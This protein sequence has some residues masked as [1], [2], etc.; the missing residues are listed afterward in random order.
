MQGEEELL[1]SHFGG[2][3]LGGG[4]NIQQDEDGERRGKQKRCARPAEAER[5]SE[6]NMITK[7]LLKVRSGRASEQ[8]SV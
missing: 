6:S 2:V 3:K 5:K 4:G 1:K 7:K 8:V